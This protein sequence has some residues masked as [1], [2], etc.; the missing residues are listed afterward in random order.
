LRD[1][2]ADEFVDYTRTTPED[3]VRDVDLVVDSVGG[4]SLPRF[5]G[6]LVY[7]ASAPLRK[8]ASVSF[9]VL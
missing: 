8:P 1:L 6:H 2:G 7:A 9:G 3:V 4:L 5:R